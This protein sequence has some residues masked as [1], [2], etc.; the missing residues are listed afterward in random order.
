MSSS[1]PSLNPK[2]SGGGRTVLAFGPSRG[3]ACHR[4]LHSFRIGSWD[5]W[6]N[7]PVIVV[8]NAV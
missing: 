4:G 3:G 8:G 7:Y 2:P 1:S 5:L 6:E